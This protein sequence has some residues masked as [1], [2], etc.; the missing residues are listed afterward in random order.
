MKGQHEA[1]RTPTGSCFVGDPQLRRFAWYAPC[2]DQLMASAY[3]ESDYGEGGARGGAVGAA[4]PPP[5]DPALCPQSTTSATV[6][7]ASARPSAP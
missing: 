3:P 4:H 2:R 7:S 6:R 5:A 1:F